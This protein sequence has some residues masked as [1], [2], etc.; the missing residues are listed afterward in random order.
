MSNIIRKISIGSD[1]KNDAMHYS[2]GQQ[3]YGGHEIA[4]IL[5]DNKDNSY[6]IFISKKDEVLPWKKFNSN[7]AISVEYDLEYYLIVLLYDNIKQIG[8]KEFIINTTIENHSFVSK[9]GR[10]VAIPSGYKTLIKVGDEV[11]VHHNIFRRWYDQKGRE[12]NSALY[13]KD[14]LYFCSPDQIY[15]YKE[16]SEYKTHLNYCFVKPLVNKSTLTTDKEISLRGILKY[17]NNSLERLG[18]NPGASVSI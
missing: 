15:L 10:V 18:L 17:T 6:N 2:V 14:D 11:I 8:D 4:D 16:N 1:Y 12:R 9:R 3:V 7:M 5:F 13:F